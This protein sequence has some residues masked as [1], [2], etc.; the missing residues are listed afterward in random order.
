MTVYQNCVHC[1]DNLFKWMSQPL[2]LGR[3]PAGNLLLSF[4]VLMAGGSISK[5]L[6]V[7]KHMGLN[8]INVRTYFA[9][10]T[11][12]LFPAV[13]H[14][15][16]NYRKML[17]DQI[18]KLKEPVWCGD[19]RFDSMG[20]CAKFEAYTMFCNSIMKIVHFE[21]LQVSQ[22]LHSIVQVLYKTLL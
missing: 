4:A 6:L 18:R 15:W 3:H 19:G 13:L 20:H 8:A 21:L 9:H 7:F 1:G 12:F 2:V 5:I 11:K 17:L 22:L 16:E 10:Q 14:Y